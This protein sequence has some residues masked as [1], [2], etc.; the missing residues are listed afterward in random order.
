MKKFIPIILSSGI[1]SRLFL[2]RFYIS[3]QEKKALQ[4]K[5]KSVYLSFNSNH[6]LLK[7]LGNQLFFKK[8][9]TEAYLGKGDIIRFENI[10]GS[11]YNH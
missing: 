7:T 8:F 2:R 11:L 4:I 6:I 3:I 1:S 10:N 5:N 9:K